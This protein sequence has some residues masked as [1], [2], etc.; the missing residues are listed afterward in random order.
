MT[1]VVIRNLDST[2]TEAQLNARF[3]AHGTVQSVTS[4]KDRDTDESRGMGFLEMADNAAAQTAI[5]SLN[6][7]RLNHREMRL[8][9]ARSKPEL[10]SAHDGSREHRRHK[11]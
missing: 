9:K 5:A 6:G 10:D 3:A 7:F 8:N 2:T 4:V 11:I 1:N